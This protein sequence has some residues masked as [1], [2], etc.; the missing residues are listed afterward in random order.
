MRGQSKIISFKIYSNKKKLGK[1][2]TLKLTQSRNFVSI[3]K[4]MKI[5]SWRLFAT[6]LETHFLCKQSGGN[7]KKKFITL[8]R[9][10]DLIEGA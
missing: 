3:V 8:R 9:E 7:L 6:G 10:M 5:Q 4:F 2:S 1:E